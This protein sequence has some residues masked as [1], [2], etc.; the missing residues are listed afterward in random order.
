MDYGADPTQEFDGT[1]AF[2]FATY[3]QNMDA[4]TL[5]F[6][7]KPELYPKSP[8]LA[9]TAAIRY[10]DVEAAHYVV[11]YCFSLKLAM[12]HDARDMIDGILL[13]RKN[14]LLREG[15][16][17]F[18]KEKQTRYTNL[19]I[20]RDDIE[21]ILRVNVDVGDERVDMPDEVIRV[22]RRSSTVDSR[23]LK[24]PGL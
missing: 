2:E 20:I 12:L 18:S 19:R 16:S 14:E 22:K 6:Q 4:L 5:L 13:E 11:W 1:N 24:M 8:Q 17:R 21:K 10:W 23:D 9:L 7:Y 3:A 15:L